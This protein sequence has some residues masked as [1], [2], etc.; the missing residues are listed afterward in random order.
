MESKTYLQMIGNAIA[1]KAQKQGRKPRL[2][3]Q[4][5]PKHPIS[6]ERE[7]ARALGEYVTFLSDLIKE[8]LLPAMPQLVAQ[9][10]FTKPENVKSDAYAD[11]FETLMSGINLAI[12]ERYTQTEIKNIAQLYGQQTA[13]MNKTIIANNIKRVVGVDVFMGDMFLPD[14]MANFAAFNANL[15]TSMKGDAIKNVSTMA[16]QGFQSG[17]RAEDIS[18]DILKYVDPRV[19]NV[20]ARANLIARDQISKLNGQLTE[21]R[22]S[23]LGINRYRW[24]TTGDDAV[25][26]SHQALDGK[27]FSWD[28]PP[29][30]GHP[31]E[32]YQCRCYAEPVLEDLVP[33][34]DEGYDG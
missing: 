29:E 12:D 25:R 1:T 18:D 3:K 5:A 27:I 15:I 22:Q 10:N 16:Y 23:D 6:V 19:G 28:D 31:G 13:R 17:R 34:L 4:L 7:Y 20:R 24:R 21:L 26:P 2:K 14:T 32:D 30:V 9:A 11:E 8:R 33:G